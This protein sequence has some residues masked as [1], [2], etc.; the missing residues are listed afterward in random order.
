MEKDK[1]SI[2][3]DDVFVLSIKWMWMLTGQINKNNCVVNMTVIM[4][5]VVIVI[6]VTVI[7]NMLNDKCVMFLWYVNDKFG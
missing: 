5:I 4:I 2:D 7:V 1:D 6:I 3:L